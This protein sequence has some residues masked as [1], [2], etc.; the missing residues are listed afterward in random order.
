M[1]R[2]VRTHGEN[3]EYLRLVA[4]L[5]EHLARVD[6][7]DHAYYAHLNSLDPPSDVVL[8]STNGGVAGCGAIRP[9]AAETME[10]KRM[11]VLPAWRR[12]GVAALILSELEEWARDRGAERCI[13][14]TGGQQPDAI[15]FY[16]RHGYQRI[17]NFGPFVA[18]A[19]SLCFEKI[20][21]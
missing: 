11:F 1:I 9:L 10:I 21:D 4:M 6:G 7:P 2:L 15:A 16:L 5:D 18:I 12:Q 14:E 13:L 20:L 8:A 3:E 17:P 19:N